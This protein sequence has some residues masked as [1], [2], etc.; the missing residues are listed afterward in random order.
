[1]R[2]SGILFVPLDIFSDYNSGNSYIVLQFSKVVLYVVRHFLLVSVH[3]LLVQI[4]VHTTT[5]SW[6]SI[7][8]YTLFQYR[9]LHVILFPIRNS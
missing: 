1:L 3:T 6:T 9:F 7:S 8:S 4:L 2:L 5:V